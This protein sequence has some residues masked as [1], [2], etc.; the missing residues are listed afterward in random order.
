MFELTFFLKLFVTG[1]AK[2]KKGNFHKLEENVRFVPI[3]KKMGR[4]FPVCA[5]LRA[6]K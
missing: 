5:K 2:R 6:N 1:L 4:L 3:E